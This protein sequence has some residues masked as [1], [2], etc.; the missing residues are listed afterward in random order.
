[1]LTRIANLNGAP[2]RYGGR[3]V[4]P[5]EAEQFACEVLQF[6]SAE[7]NNMRFNAQFARPFFHPSYIICG[8]CEL[9]SDDCSCTFRVW[10][11]ALHISAAQYHHHYLPKRRRSNSVARPATYLPIAC[12]T[13]GEVRRFHSRTKNK[14]P[15]FTVAPCSPK[16]EFSSAYRGHIVGL[17]VLWDRDSGVY[18]QRGGRVSPR[19]AHPQRPEPLPSLPYV[20][21][22]HGGLG[23]KAVVMGTIEAEKT[24]A[25]AH[26]TVKERRMT[27]E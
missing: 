19:M 13:R 16:L 24:I 14:S 7:I 20:V 4:A 27:G 10:G 12:R 26:A 21:G 17:M 22:R 9:D 18:L 23:V 6:F 25:A 2:V 8:C 3:V 15:A 11:P 1:M 5:S